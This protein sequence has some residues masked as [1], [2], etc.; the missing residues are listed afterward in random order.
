MADKK[1]TYKELKEQL[2]EILTKLESNE[3]DIDEAIEL[4]GKGNSI[5]KKLENYLKTTVEKSKID[6]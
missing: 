5:I 6:L 4:H 2:D 1:L 3:L